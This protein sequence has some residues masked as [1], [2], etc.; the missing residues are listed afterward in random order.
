MSAFTERIRRIIADELGV[1]ID[2]IR[3]DSDLVNDLGAD[4]IDVTWLAL[5]FER[6]F[7]IVVD[8]VEFVKLKTV[9]DVIDCL[10][11]LTGNI[12]TASE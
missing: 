11:R 12:E 2:D 1:S 6:E 7:G 9:G 4:S 10:A 5:A 3:S 8:D